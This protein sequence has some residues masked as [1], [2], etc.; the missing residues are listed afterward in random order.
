MNYLLALVFVCIGL[1]AIFYLRPKIMK[2]ILEIQYM[3]TKTI[4]ELKD[5]FKDMDANGLGNEYREFVELKGKIVSNNPVQGPYSKKTVAYCDSKLI[6]VVE[7]REEYRD[8]NN[9]LRTRTIKHENVLSNQKTSENLNMKDETSE[10]SIILEI[11]ATGCELDI[12]ETFNKFENK[13]NLRN[14]D[15]FRSFSL[16]RISSDTLGFKMVE[17][18]IDINQNIYVIGEAFRVGNTI[19]IGKPMDDK[20]PFIVSTKSEEDL[21]NN[22]KR[23]TMLLLIGGIISIVIGIFMFIK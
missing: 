2:N 22:S 4:S 8:N 11:N 7:T 3:K 12:P 18:T 9:N 5:M 13:S 19:H 15:Y 17:R 16:D 1:A 6:Q 10:D 14:Y 20:K 23:K 21:I